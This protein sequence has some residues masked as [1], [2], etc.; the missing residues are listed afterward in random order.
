M[1]ERTS[2]F[3]PSDE[4]AAQQ[5]VVEGEERGLSTEVEKTDAGFR[6]GEWIAV[7]KDSRSFMG[8]TFKKRVIVTHTISDTRFVVILSR[9]C[10]IKIDNVA[11]RFD[12]IP[13]CPEVTLQGQC[14]PCTKWE[15]AVIVT[16]QNGLFAPQRRSPWVPAHGHGI[17]LW[18]AQ[19]ALRRSC[20]GD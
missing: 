19:F 12:K 17:L 13:K 5:R 4:F 20:F 7:G 10:E 16:I 1:T 9:R 11:L 2:S 18:A 3:R 6:R 15:M 14:S 8:G